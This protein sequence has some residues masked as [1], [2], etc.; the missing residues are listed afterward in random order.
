MGQSRV[1]KAICRSGA[2]L[3]ALAL[4]GAGATALTVIAAPAAAQ[5]FT[6]VTATGR[7]QDTTG[8]AIAGATVTV[9]SDAQGF[10]RTTTTNDA[11]AFEIPSLPSGNYTFT[12]AAPGFDTLTEPGV[13]LDRANSANQFTIAAAGAAAPVGNAIIVTGRRQIV[14]FGETTTGDVINIGEI[15]DTVPVA[16]DLTSVIELAP[17]TSSGDSSFG[18]L[19]SIGGASV[20]EN[21][22]YVNGLNTTNFR[23][24]LAPATV[25]FEFYETVEV[26]NGGFQAEFGRATGGFVNAITKSGSN[27]Y[28]GGVLVTYEPKGL[29]EQAPNTI[30][31]DNELDRSERIDTNVY[32]SG[33]I[34][35]DRLFVYGLYNNRYNKD[36]FASLTTDNYTIRDDNSPFYAF[37]ID[38]I[39]IDGQR[40]EFT[41]FDTSGTIRDRTFSY[42]PDT[43]E[44]GEFNNTTIFRT[45]GENYV[46]RYT[47]TFTD[48]LTLSAA[49]GVSNDRADTGTT[50]D[51]LSAAR[52]NRGDDIVGFGNSTIVIENNLDSRE[53]YRGDVDLF[54]DL[55]GSH[56]IR[57]GYD[58][59]ELTSDVSTA[60]TG[61]VFYQYFT[62]VDAEDPYAPPGTDYV[63]GRTFING[64]VFEVVNEAFYIQDQ[65]TLFNDR[66]TLNLGI[67]NDRFT[68][69]NANGE[70]FYESGD[71]WG[72]RLGAT[73]D[74]FGDGGTKAYGFFGRYFLP[75]AAN[76]N[77]RLAGAELDY[78]RYFELDGLQP[79]GLPILGDP[80]TGFAG[81]TACPD[82]GVANCRINADG[83]VAPTISTIA[84]SLQPQYAD[85][86]ILGLE[87]RLGDRLTVEL[88]GTYETLG[89]ALEDVAID[90]AVLDY[91]EAEGIEGCEA[92]YTGFHQY[93]LV[94]P[95]VDATITLNE[96]LP[97]DP[98][99]TL[100]TVDFTAEQLGY[101][102]A[103][104]EYKAL[105]LKVNREFDGVW[106]LSGSYTLSETEGNYEGAV[107]S[108]IGQADPGITQDFDQPGLVDG[109]FGL[110]PTH[111]AHNFKLYGSYKVFDW[112]TVGGNYSLLSPRKYGCIGRVP[113]D[114][115]FFAQFYG[116]AGYYC[117]VDENGDVQTTTPEDP[118]P[119]TPE[120]EGL[121]PQELTPRGSRFESDWTSTLNLSA[122][123][124]LPTD[125]FSSFLRV[126]AFNILNEQAVID[127]NEFGTDDSGNP[128]PQYMAPISYQTPRYIR[129]Q[130]G[131][132]F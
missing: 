35:K 1:S 75:I 79:N 73:F 12:I 66:L 78:T 124:T 57:G 74:V 60:Y 112:L 121:A 89:R 93:V 13:M 83:S 24:F 101:P 88:Y 40:L 48:W 113:A 19:A 15:A 110:L 125:A 43:N 50:N 115:D 85:E 90:A 20:A 4:L 130:F 37:K 132:R 84:Q 9:T 119:A 77:Q 25:P 18:N 86:Y 8:A 23:T 104:R 54:F 10:S 36:T 45:G 127:L 58:R 129:F 70:V 116:A 99:G 107:K 62:A 59:E 97:G 92:I 26:K 117:R 22:F 108:D 122:I 33:P 27:E 95:G 32:L 11:G 46:G 109:T 80:L 31:A 128:N 30:T 67:R 5:D 118:N 44:I 68:N 53:F 56:H 55:F 106:G 64:G 123:F 49:Y 29:G 114:V 131:V 3:Q 61:N 34:I 76:T 38:A 72:P 98:A 16:R 103:E 82:T 6:N 105:T 28:H 96:T 94:N 63:S 17:G 100:R 21:A 39:P 102:E 111:R 42:D 126:D 7:V 65:W 47:G 2:A 81:A 87:H 120:N 91:C 52:D 69:K 14:D 51:A 41:Y 71:Q